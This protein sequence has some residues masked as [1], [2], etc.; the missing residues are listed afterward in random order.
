MAR[1]LPLNSRYHLNRCFL[2]SLLA[3]TT[4][5]MCSKKTTLQTIN[6]TE[7]TVSEADYD[8]YG[9]LLLLQAMM[10]FH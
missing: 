4:K 9:N 6:I 7:K 3:K 10:L 8:I 5:I 2:F 1:I